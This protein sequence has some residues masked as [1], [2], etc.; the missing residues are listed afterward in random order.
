MAVVLFVIASIGFSIFVNSFGSY[1]AT[2]GA[3]AGVIV[4]L[5]WLYI[6][7]FIV[8]LGAELKRRDGAPDAPRHHHR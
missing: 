8:L 6:T 4:L 7:S 1:D 2:Y 5:L 3:L